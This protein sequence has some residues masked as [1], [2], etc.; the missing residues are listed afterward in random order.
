MYP[1]IE[2]NLFKMAEALNTHSIAK[3]GDICRVK[4][5]MIENVTTGRQFTF[6]NSIMGF[7]KEFMV[8]EGELLY[9]NESHFMFK[10][11]DLY[12]ESMLD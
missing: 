12:I 6:E 3:K 1:L 2:R 7:P 8:L 5:M 4:F 9:D 11:N 10:S